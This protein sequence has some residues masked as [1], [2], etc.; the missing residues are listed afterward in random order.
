MRFEVYKN[1]KRGIDCF[2][3]LGKIY[4]EN[5][6]KTILTPTCTLFMPSGCVPFVT[7]DLLKHVNHVPLTAEIP[8][9]SM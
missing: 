2:E 5:N 9:S 8:F 1:T 6:E 4:Y 3:R 7:N